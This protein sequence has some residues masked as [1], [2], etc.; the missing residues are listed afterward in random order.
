MSVKT[1][2]ATIFED[3]LAVGETLTPIFIHN[4]R[5]QTITTILTTDANALIQQLAQSGTVVMQPAPPASG[6]TG[7]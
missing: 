4:A 1:T 2:L 6:T 7:S 5:S 3:I